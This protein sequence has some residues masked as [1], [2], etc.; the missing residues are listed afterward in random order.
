[1]AEAIPFAEAN[2]NLTAPKGMNEVMELP[3][4]TD[5]K[6]CIS[7]WRFTKP[8]IEEIVKTGHVWLFVVS[9]STQPPVAVSGKYPFL[10]TESK[11]ED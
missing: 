9:G 2:S 3:I 10:T 8:E 7:K 1:M 11:R 6:M 5:G 4:W